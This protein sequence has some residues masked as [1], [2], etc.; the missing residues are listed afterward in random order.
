MSDGQVSRPTPTVSAFLREVV[1]AGGSAHVVTFEE[2]VLLHIL[3][4]VPPVGHDEP[5]QPPARQTCQPD[6]WWS[7]RGSCSGR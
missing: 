2:A 5:A 3:A 7:R 4:P 6:A 1:A